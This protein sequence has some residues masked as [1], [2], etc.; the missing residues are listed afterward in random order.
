V[1]TISLKKVSAV[2]VASLGFGLLSVVPAQAADSLP[3]VGTATQPGVVGTPRAT[4]IGITAGAT[5]PADA[6][7][8]VTLTVPTGSRVT[9]ADNDGSY[10][11]DTTAAF[12]TTG[13]TTGNTVAVSA[14]TG[15]VTGTTTAAAVVLGTITITPDVPGLY[16]VNMNVAG[17]T[18]TSAYIQVAGIAGTVG[19]SGLGTAAVAATTG[20]IATFTYTTGSAA[21]SGDIFRFTSSGVGAITGATGVAANGTSANH[22]TE[23]SGVSGSWAGGATW[24]RSDASAGT[25]TITVSS[26]TAGTQTVTV[27]AISATTGAP[28]STSTISITWGSAVAISAASTAYMAGPAES[29]DANFTST[30]NAIPRSADKAAGTAVAT[31]AITIVG[32]KGTADARANT[33]RATMSGT[34]FVDVNGTVGS[35]SNSSQRTDANTEADAS[36]FV[37]VYSDGTSGTGTLT[38]TLTDVDSGASLTLGTWTVTSTGSQASIAVAATNYTVGRAGYTTGQASTAISAAGSALSPL[39]TTS[40]DTATRV[41]AFVIVVKD[42]SG[43]AVNASATPAVISSDTTVSSGGTCALDAGSPTYGSSTNGIGYYNCSFATT[44]TAK[45]GAKAT[46]TIRIADPLSTTGG[47][48]TTTVAVT[49][50]EK[51]AKTTLSLDKTSYAPGEAMIVTAKAVDASG[52][53]VYDGAASVVPTSSKALGGTAL[54]SLMTGW[55]V[56][57]VDASSTTVAKAKVFAPAQSG[58][59]T[60]TGTDS[61]LAIVTAAASVTDANAGLLTQIDALNAKIVALN[62]L[63][64]K[65]MKKLGVK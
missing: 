55:Y 59:F 51:N 50:G 10:S 27:N 29:T 58:S 53:P 54:S 1:K 63:I 46:L 35:L 22:P 36:R 15:V 37:R 62:A 19:T 9:L 65:I 60:L 21:S 12:A 57:G 13:A 45:S 38:V 28:T 6:N 41:G 40:T 8:K 16:K 14:T 24:T 20:G 61:T 4:T 17:T 11:T 3:T 31:V 25:A 34:G 44:S 49:V 30:S 18:T 42:S 52:N 56:G 23:I 26:T 48:L 47:Y 43:N 33:V 32:S 7:T 39:D 64:A 2:A 5:A